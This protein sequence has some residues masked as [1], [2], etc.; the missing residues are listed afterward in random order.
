MIDI[1]K[2]IG[3][4]ISNL[5]TAFPKYLI[6]GTQCILDKEKRKNLHLE[7]SIIPTTI[8]TLS[9]IT[10]LIS[11]FLLTRWYVQNERIKNFSTTLAEQTEI[12]TKE[13]KNITADEETTENYQEIISPDTSNNKITTN[14]DL[15]YL[16]INFDYYLK[17]NDETVAWIKVNGTNINY[18]IVKHS[19]ND[20]YLEHDFYQKKSSTGWV[21]ADYRNDFENLS[22]NTILYAHNLI[23][24]TM[25]GSLPKLLN[26]NWFQTE[27]NKYIKISTPNYNSIWQIFSVYKIEPTVDYLKTKFNDNNNYQEFLDTI[28]NRSSYNFNTSI[29]Y[30]DKILTLSTCDDTGTKRVVVHA[31][32]YSMETK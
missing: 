9:L 1:F 19:D 6:L 2:K 7:K 3:K 12:I 24:R 11:I 23:N 17:K 27:N 13:E 29:D 25:F 22:N 14:P 8:T 18:P 28:K 21:F 15:S 16:N 20:Y 5:L 26:K 32:L 30:N 10:Y 31:K 4:Q